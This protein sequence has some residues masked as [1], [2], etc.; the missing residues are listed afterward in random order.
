MDA[1]K[2]LSLREKIGQTVVTNGNPQA[3]IKAY[4]SLEAFLNKFPIG[5]VFVGGEIIKDLTLEAGQVR[6]AVK[7]YKLASP[8]PMLF[9]SDME[10][11]CGSMVRGLTPF[12]YLM[13]LGATGSEALAYDYG[14]ATAL[15]ALSIG[16]NWTF[17]PVADLNQ[18]RFNPITNIRAVSDDPE[19]TR[20]LLVQVVKGMQANG[21]SATAK[22]FPGDGID[23]R[24][25][26]LVTTANSLTFDQWI[27]NHG[28]V[29]KSLID[30]EVNSIMTGHITLQ[31]FQEKKIDG[32]FPPATLSYELTTTLLKQKLGFRGVVV[33][34]AL[35]M[36]GFLGWFERAQAEIECFKAGTD[37]LL[38]PLPGYM[39]SMEQAIQS[40]EI[41]IDRLNDAVARIWRMK[42]ERNLFGED[43]GFNA[44]NE[45]ERIYI[46]TTAEKVAEQS[47]T[48]L[49][50]QHAILPLK[51][52][53]INKVL[54]VGITAHDPTFVEMGI[55]QQ[56]LQTRGIETNLQ[57]NISFSEVELA[58]D[59]DW[60][61]YALSTRPHQ[62][63][64]PVNFSGHEAGAIW[65]SLSAHRYKS[66]VISFGSPYF[67][68]DYYAAAP[69]YINAYNSIPASFV[70]VIKALFGE[71]SFV[72]RSP[73]SMD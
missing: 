71:I 39:D 50:D 41:S 64:G 59:Y 27:H 13:A 25:Q 65:A 33:S 19:L 1:W 58:T 70:A 5:G 23:Y 43:T 51:L 35:I 31:H 37:M 72:G 30:A 55:L 61:I 54:I 4:G 67:Y 6:E 66:I 47:I 48:L 73:V 8:I 52:Q 53:G 44:L 10:N 56:E 24:D 46:Q 57:R 26:H 62:P 2:K 12:P 68:V 9:A 38:W 34:D 28:A 22:H 40:G 17:S 16:V 60:I 32:R 21:L 14:K 11:G 15:E 20:R 36:G 49:R 3:E 45:Q 29:F 63:M 69:I 42:H 7:A 18:N